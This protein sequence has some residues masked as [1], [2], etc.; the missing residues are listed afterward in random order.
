[1]TYRS[2]TEEARR[3]D[4]LTKRKQRMKSLPDKTSQYG[5]PDRP[6]NFISPDS[7]L[8]RE[9]QDLQSEEELTTSKKQALSSSSTIKLIPNSNPEVIG[10]NVRMKFETQPGIEEW[11]SGMICLYNEIT[12]NMAYT[13][14]VMDKLLTRF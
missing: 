14:P 2:T 6:S 8:K 1:L 5:P 9:R 10:K 11:Y 4:A 13:F 12:G 3:K 7:S